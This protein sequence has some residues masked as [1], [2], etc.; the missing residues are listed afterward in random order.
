VV[1]R[2]LSILKKELTIR[3]QKNNASIALSKYRDFRVV[4]VSTEQIF[5]QNFEAISAASNL[6]L[7]NTRFTEN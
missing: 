7:N 2:V 1:T 3:S 4:S 6:A 5:S